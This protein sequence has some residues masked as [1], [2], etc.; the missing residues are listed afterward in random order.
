MC[1]NKIVDS[2]CKCPRYN[3]EI[4]ESS[5]YLEQKGKPCFQIYNHLILLFIK[6]AKRSMEFT[7]KRFLSVVLQFTQK[8]MGEK[9]K[10]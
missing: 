3:T 5:V 1:L 10:E 4:Q 7:K 9:E 8:K 6:T 2:T